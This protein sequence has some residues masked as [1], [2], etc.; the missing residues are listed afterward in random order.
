MK[1]NMTFQK[2]H[3]ALIAAACSGIVICAAALSHAGELKIQPFTMTPFEIKA[4]IGLV[5]KDSA[6]VKKSGGKSKKQSR[7]TSVSA[8][9]AS[10]STLPTTPPPHPQSKEK[11]H[12]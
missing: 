5:G 11:N 3:C 12:E 9:M 8:K 6:A 4:D 2:L 1:K 7:K 10:A